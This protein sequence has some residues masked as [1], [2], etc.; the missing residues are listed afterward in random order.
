MPRWQKWITAEYLQGITRCLRI[1][2]IWFLPRLV[3]DFKS[4]TDINRLPNFLMLWAEKI[5]G[6]NFLIRRINN[7]NEFFDAFKK[8][9]LPPEAGYD[10]RD[11]E[12]EANNLF[13]RF[14][15]ALKE[16]YWEYFSS[17]NG[18]FSRVLRG[19]D[20]PPWMTELPTAVQGNLRYDAAI[21]R[22]DDPHIMPEVPFTGIGYLLR[23]DGLFKK[24]A[25]ALYLWRLFEI[26]QL[27][28]LT[29]PTRD[30]PQR[31]IHSRLAHSMTVYVIMAL[32]L[33][34]NRKAIPKGL[35]KNGCV[36]A[37]IHD[38]ATVAG[39]D[40]TKM[41]DP[42]YFCE[43]K[44]FAEYLNLFRHRWKKICEDLGLDESWITDIVNGCG[45]GG[46][47]LNISD[48][49]GYGSYDTSVFLN[50][51]C[52]NDWRLQPAGYT[53]VQDFI[54]QNPLAFS[55][56][57]SVKVMGDE[58]FFLSPESLGQALFARAMMIE[59]LYYEKDSRSFEA[60]LA[61][62]VLKYLFAKGKLDRQKLFLMNDNDL[63]EIVSQFT[64]IP[65]SFHYGHALGTIESE[66]FAS[67]EE[68]YRRETEIIASGNAFVVLEDC[69]GRINPATDF[70]TLDH[71]KR[72]R[73]FSEAC[74]EMTEKIHEKTTLKELIF[75]HRLT[76]VEIKPSVAKIL[77]KFHLQELKRRDQNS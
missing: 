36:A 48:K 47:I 6:L 28:N 69:R 63:E 32:I 20:E 58:V 60:V 56:W 66:A 7:F 52:P 71:N 8:N 46:K 59:K 23:E 34:N 16:I 12:G 26:A 35:F 53:E 73:P 77:E 62:I 31:F 18:N 14:L 37:L 30:Y 27:S 21:Q 25:D 1:G 76:S 15:F 39:G 57:D 2:D 17:H 61:N 40:G 72:I 44:N 4:F 45:L 43:E 54:Q 51:Y 67:I 22:F 24:V 9:L 10:E 41:V 13:L 49:W 11:V 42:G 5:E 38:I 3:L 29:D 68:A 50:R 75:L 74:P 33:F 55:A 64:G 19:F 65:F 70:L